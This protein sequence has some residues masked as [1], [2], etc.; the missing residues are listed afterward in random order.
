MMQ[1]DYETPQRVNFPP[2][3]INVEKQAFFEYREKF[4][5]QQTST[6]ATERI[7]K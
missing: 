4:H 6:L 5:K 1:S 7:L 2:S 3:F